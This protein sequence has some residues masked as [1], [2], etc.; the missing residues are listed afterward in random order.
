MVSAPTSTDRVVEIVDCTLRDGEQSPGV[1][2][3]VDEKLRL[4]KMLD[5]AGVDVLDAGFPAADGAE[6]ECLQEMRRLG[7]RARIGATARPLRS[8]IEAAEQARAHEVFMFLPTSDLRLQET[9][10]LTRDKAAAIF[11]IGAEQV[12][13]RGMKLN[14]VFEDATR[15]APELLLRIVED[16]S[17]RLP[18]ERVVLCD[19]VGC[20]TPESIAALVCRM[21]SALGGTLRLVT[22][23]HNDFGL[24]VA[25][26]LS[27]IAAGA[28]AASCT[29]NG[30]GER[31]GNADLAETV[32]A[33]THLMHLE[34]GIDPLALPSLSE[35]V[36]KASGI[37]VGALKPVT[38]FN[39]YRHES[40]IHASA[41][42]KNSASYEF[43]PAAWTGNRAEYVLGKHSGSGQVRHALAELGMSPTDEQVANWLALIKRT[44]TARDKAEHFSAYYN[45]RRTTERLLSGVELA[46]LL[47]FTKESPRSTLAAPQACH[48]IGAETPRRGPTPL[49]SAAHPKL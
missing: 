34:H 43:L 16:I 24:A 32:A 14:L 9:L 12:L 49:Y 29:V 19:T 40:G 21:R 7:L 33:L 35:Y 11:E 42:L 6:I 1:W 38:G 30:I 5:G 15:A 18:V 8:D 23:C 20:A 47:T 36:E 48:A 46:E 22:H 31:A 27:G 10:G 26:T 39:V 4:A 13:S 41:M 25:N 3:A 45:K 17:R 44:A 37:H 2:F 28:S